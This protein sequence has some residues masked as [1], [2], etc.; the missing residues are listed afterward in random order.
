MKKVVLFCLCVTVLSLQSCVQQE[1]EDNG[2][3][4]QVDKKKI[5]RPGDQG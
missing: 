3:P 4:Q 2:E 1:L 5:V